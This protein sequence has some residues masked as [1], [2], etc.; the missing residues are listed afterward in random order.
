MGKGASLGLGE[1]GA[2][3][4][5]TARNARELEATAREITRSGAGRAIAM[6]CDHR[7][8]GEVRAVFRR[9]EAEHGRLD[10]LVNSVFPGEP[11]AARFW[12]MPVAHWDELTTVGLRSHVVASA[13]AA[14]LM[15]AGG[16]GLIVFMSSAGSGGVASGAVKAAVDRLAAD[17]AAELRP[18]G[19]AAISLWPATAELTR[20]VVAALAAD[21]NVL[22]RSG[23][24]L[25][26]LD[27]AAEYG[28]TVT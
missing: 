3:V 13:L 22:E 11:P 27:L 16:S 26:A 7:E 14:P 19:V 10:V 9:L 21:Q 20:S 24:V 17:M 25:S 12:D 2:T 8:D 6:P 23:R 15:I 18:H 28:L 5:L 1:A 4:Y